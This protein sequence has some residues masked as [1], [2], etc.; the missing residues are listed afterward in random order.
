[1]LRVGTGIPPGQ[2]P[3]GRGQAEAEM[4]RPA[5]RS[6]GAGELSLEVDGGLEARRLKFKRPSDGRHGIPGR[7]ERDHVG[8]D[9]RASDDRGAKGDVRVKHD[10]NSPTQREPPLGERG[11]GFE[12]DLL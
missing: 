3:A 2:A 8:A 1:M 4:S 7:I 9:V 6:S 11:A 5:R 12:V 10:G